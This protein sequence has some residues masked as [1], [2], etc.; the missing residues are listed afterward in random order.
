MDGA[1]ALELSL[2]LNQNPRNRLSRHRHCHVTYFK[3]VRYR[4]LGLVPMPPRAW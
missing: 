1:S 4:V 2:P 3:N